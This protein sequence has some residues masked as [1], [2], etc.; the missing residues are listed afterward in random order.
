[1][2]AAFGVAS[3]GQGLETTLAQIIAEHLG[4]R[5]EDIR[6]VQGDSAAVAR[7]HRHLRQPQPGAGRRRRD[8]GGTSRAREGAQR[9]LAS[10]RGG[11]PPTSSPKTAAISVAGTDRSVTFREVARAVYSEMGRLPP[12]A[13]EELAATENLRPD[14]RH[15]D[16]GDAYRGASKSTRD[17]PGARRCATSSRKIAAGWSIR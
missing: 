14:I 13:R 17:L 16:V 5:F 10:A 12:E 3:H 7:R 11:A 4:V 9:R 8:A 1:M 2:T 6:V 15:D